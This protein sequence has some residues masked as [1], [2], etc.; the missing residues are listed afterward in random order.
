MRGDAYRPRATSNVAAM[1]KNLFIVQIYKKNRVV[2]K[3]IF[4]ECCFKYRKF[5]YFFHCE[6]NVIMIGLLF[7]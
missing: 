1:I 2:A 7:S 4:H 5:Q 6:E 3:T